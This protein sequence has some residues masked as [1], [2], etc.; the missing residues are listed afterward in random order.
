LQTSPRQFFRD[1]CG[2]EASLEHPATAG[3]GDG[4]LTIDVAVEAPS[5]RHLLRALSGG[6]GGAG[7]PVEGADGGGVEIGDSGG[8]VRVAVE[9]DGPTHFAANDASRRLGPTV[10]RDWL[11]AR[12]GWRV[13]SVRE[14]PAAS[15]GARRRGVLLESVSAALGATLGASFGEPPTFT[16]I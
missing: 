9:A 1:E 4:G 11:L 8:G 3:A 7:A 2:L 13:A 6:G 10:A 5:A 16:K 15:E 12:L 14:W